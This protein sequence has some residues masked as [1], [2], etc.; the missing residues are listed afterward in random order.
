ML[1]FDSDLAE[2]WILEL[3]EMAP[4]PAKTA[5]LRQAEVEKLLKRRRI[6]RISAAEVLAILKEQALT[7]APGVA[8]AAAA[9][10]RALMRPKTK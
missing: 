6:R 5:R 1:Q 7:V 2:E 8:E 4:T 9:H 10:I 3:W